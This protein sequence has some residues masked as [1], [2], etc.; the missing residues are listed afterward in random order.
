MC[1]RI[2]RKIARLS[3]AELSR[4]TGVDAGLLCHVEAGDLTLVRYQ[5]VAAVADALNIA[6][7]ELQTFIA[8]PDPLWQRRRRASARRKRR[9]TPTT[10]TA[11][12][13]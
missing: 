3:Q 4:R 8:I 1:L 11:D 5:D 13:A 12:R 6:P 9:P 7:D 10:T 2:A